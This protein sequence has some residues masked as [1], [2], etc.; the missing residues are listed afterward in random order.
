MGPEA[1][2]RREYSTKNDIWGLGV[3]MYEIFE[4]RAPWGAQNE[5]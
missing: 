5:K 1:L 2:T 4:G 3:T